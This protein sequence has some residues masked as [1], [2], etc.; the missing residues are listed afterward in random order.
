MTA[1]AEGF[2]LSAVPVPITGFIAAQLDGEPVYLEPEELGTTPLQLPEGYKKLGLFSSDGGPQDA[3]DKDDDSEFFQDGYKL[4]GASTRTLQVTLSELND[5]VENLITGKTP[6]EHGVI[7]VDDD[8]SAV[9]PIFEVLKYK[10]G[11]ERRRNGLARISTVEP[12]QNERGTANGNSVTFEWV[13]KEDWGGFYREWRKNRAT[14]GSTGS[15]MTNVPVTGITITPET[16]SVEAGQSTQLTIAVSP[17]NATNTAF[18]VASADDS[19]ITVDESGKAT[20]LAGS[21]G[22]VKVT[23]TTADGSKTA[24]ATITITP[25]SEG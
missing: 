11:D 13:R 1:D 5:T 4:P 6:D 25:A 20:A 9:F 17:S 3:S 16:V 10:N 7:V 8:N 22:D 14:S 18:T 12:D 19:K 21:E 24:S 15:G 2:D 23:A